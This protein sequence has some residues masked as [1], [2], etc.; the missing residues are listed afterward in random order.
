[1]ARTS[2]EKTIDRLLTLYSINECYKQCKV[3]GLSETKL[4]KLVFLSEKRLIDQRIKAFNYHFVRL[5]H[6]TFSTELRNDLNDFVK[7]GYLS[8]PWLGQTEKTL[9]ILKDFQDVIARNPHVTNVIDSI[10]S[11]FAD[12]PTS[13][14]VQ[15]VYSMPWTR[16]KIINE[17]TIGVPMLYPLDPDKAREKFIITEDELENL[18]I[19]LNPKISG[20]LDQAFDEMR[21]GRLLSHAEVFG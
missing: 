13:R 5:L 6:P 20:T 8:E 14:L 9:I 21:R 3:T 10:I 18:E 16:N 2:E 15:I 7:T 12:I 11:T 17:L 19:C 1:M 4:Q